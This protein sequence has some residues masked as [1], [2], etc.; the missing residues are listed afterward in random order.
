MFKDLQI[1]L[2]FLFLLPLK[3]MVC[4]SEVSKQRV[5]L[6]WGR[7]GRGRGDVDRGF[8]LVGA[9]GGGTFHHLFWM[10]LYSAALSNLENWLCKSV[11]LQ[12]HSKPPAS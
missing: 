3:G 12:T 4:M 5:T 1:K 6:L 2:A 11:W 10:A 9:W 8:S 7:K